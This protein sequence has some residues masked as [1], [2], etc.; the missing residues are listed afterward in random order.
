MIHEI[1]RF[2]HKE[3]IGSLYLIQILHVDAQNLVLNNM[4]TNSETEGPQGLRSPAFVT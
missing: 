1:T 2:F 4:A 3:F